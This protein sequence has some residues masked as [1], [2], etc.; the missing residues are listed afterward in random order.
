MPD[1]YLKKAA[2]VLEIESAVIKDLTSRIDSTFQQA[3]ETIYHIDGKVIVTGMGKSGLVGRKLAAT[4]SST[5]TPSF[6]LHPTEAAHG[7]LGGISDGDLL[8]MISKSGETSE[9]IDL[10]P[11]LRKLHIPTIG[12]IGNTQSRLAKKCD[13][14]L[15]IEVKSEACP[16]GIVPTA[17]T[18]ATSAMG[19]A[20]AIALLDKRDFDKKDFA[21][22]HPGGSLGRRL[23]TTVEDLMHTDQEIPLASIDQPMKEV[24]ITMT[25]KGLG[26]VG[27]LDNGSELCGVITDG[28]LRRGLE[29]GNDFLGSSPEELMTTNPK[30]IKKSTL[31]ID[32][33][34]IMEKHAITSLFVFKE[35]NQGEPIGIIHIHDILSYGIMS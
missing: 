1:S 33:L 28:D 35:T 5:G 12:M 19:D 9:L 16:L 18:I 11:S 34:N 13:I 23:L 21:D 4:L 26:V 22:L 6:F 29:S 20:L 24:L 7:D 30:W 27:I 10:V 17:S 32:A 15:N 14:V 8:I 3:V 2:E 25:G 31:A